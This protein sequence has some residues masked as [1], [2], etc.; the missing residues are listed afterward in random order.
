MHKFISLENYFDHIQDKFYVL[1]ID[2]IWSA[3]WDINILLQITAGYRNEQ[4]AYKDNNQ[5]IF[6]SRSKSLLKQSHSFAVFLFD[7]LK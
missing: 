5:I 2:E 1:A 4:K 3:T 6:L 7:D